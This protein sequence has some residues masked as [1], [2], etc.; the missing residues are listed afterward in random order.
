M[1]G[2][3]SLNRNV[4]RAAGAGRTAGCPPDDRWPQLVLGLLDDAERAPLLTHA[5]G[6]DHCSIHLAEAV[7]A[8]DEP[9]PERSSLLDN[10]PSSSPAGRE[11]LLRTAL[12]PRRP[13]LSWL[14]FAAA[15][16]LA[17][18]G[19]LLLWPQWQLYRAQEEIAARYSQAR[20]S[21]FRLAGLPWGPRGIVRGNVQQPGV[22]LPASAQGTSAEW[23][24]AFLEQD[25]ARAV[26]LIEKAHR[27]NPAD[28]EIA[29]DLAAALAA[30]SQ[31]SGSSE[32]ALRA[33]S[34]LD[35]ILRRHPTHNAARFNRLM[36]LEELGRS[37]EAAREA[38]ELSANAD[39]PEWVREATENR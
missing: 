3:D 22:P 35:G 14:A 25:Y 17:A 38:S 36:I 1:P 18:A 26:L 34:I 2:D 24:N 21:Q 13:L 30:Q 7:S 29:N 19:G 5:A 23:R 37:S 27:A 4:L 6:C 10:L 39:D 8:C 33:L 32:M 12:Q 20:G 15:I 16:L 28:A 11:R 31:T 9:D